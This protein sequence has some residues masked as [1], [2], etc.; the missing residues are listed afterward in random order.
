MDS[1][2]IQIGSY[3]A[4]RGNPSC[5]GCAPGPSS[6]EL[7]NLSSGRMIS[8]QKSAKVSGIAE[9]DLSMPQ[10]ISGPEC[11]LDA[12]ATCTWSPHRYKHFPFGGMTPRHTVHP[13]PARYLGHLDERQIRELEITTIRQTEYTKGSPLGGRTEYLRSVGRVIGWDDGREAE[14]SYVECS[15][16]IHQGRSFHGRPAHRANVKV[17]HLQEKGEAR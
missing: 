5:V 10:S 16:G 14:F 13:N 15:G 8:S 2:R 17:L 1:R 11:L 12:R 7:F 6:S 4:L 9:R 3:W